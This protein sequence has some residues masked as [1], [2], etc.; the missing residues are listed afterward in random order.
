MDYNLTIKIMDIINDYCHSDKNNFCY[1]T[2]IKKITLYKILSGENPNPTIDTI[3]KIKVAFPEVNLNWLLFDEKIKY[4][5][6]Y[7]ILVNYCKELE[8]KNEIKNDLKNDLIAFLKTKY[9]G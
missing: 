5:S 3:I 1:H 8:T 9:L 6:D 4:K 7:E 2:G